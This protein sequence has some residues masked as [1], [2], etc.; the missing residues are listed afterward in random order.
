MRFATRRLAIRPQTSSGELTNSSGPGC[1][2]NCWKPA[3]MMAAVAVVG[4]PK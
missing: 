4:R 2:P 1:S 3:R